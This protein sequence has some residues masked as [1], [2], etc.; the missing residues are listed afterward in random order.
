M[1]KSRTK[2]APLLAHPLIGKRIA[3]DVSEDTNV[4]RK[5]ETVK[6]VLASYDGTALCIGK[7]WFWT[8]SVTNLR[9]T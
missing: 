6:G 4:G 1:A 3:G 8:S 9:E 7:R 2:E 5:A